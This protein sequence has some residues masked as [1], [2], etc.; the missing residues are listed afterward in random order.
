MIQQM[1]SPTSRILCFSI[2]TLGLTGVLATSACGSS[3]KPWFTD[4][5]KA[6]LEGNSCRFLEGTRDPASENA[7]RE[8]KAEVRQL[9]AEYLCSTN[10]DSFG[11][12]LESVRELRIICATWN[13]LDLFAQSF[14][15]QI[16]PSLMSD[17]VMWRNRNELQCRR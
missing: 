13:K 17:L 3:Q 5:E 1:K 12:P 14:P 8:T 6:D 7:S 9:Y 10:L 16:A 4:I 15:D 11:D 2:V